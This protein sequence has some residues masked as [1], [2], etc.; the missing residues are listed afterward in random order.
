[1]HDDRDG[2]PPAPPGSPRQDLAVV[3]AEHP[4]WH[5]WE[6]VIAGVLYAR[7]TRSSPPRVVRATSLVALAAA[8]EADER[9][10]GER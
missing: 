1:M 10:A 7:R 5:T 2:Y 3:E 8:I 9:Q 4:G 6:G